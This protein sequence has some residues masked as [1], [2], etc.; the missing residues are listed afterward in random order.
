MASTNFGR[1]LKPTR[2]AY[3]YYYHYREPLRGFGSMS[4]SLDA[5]SVRDDRVRVVVLTLGDGDFSWSLDLARYLLRTAL[6]K[7]S[8]DEGPARTN[9]ARGPRRQ[10][11]LIATG[12]D[13][14]SE[15]QSKYKADCEFALRELKRIGKEDPQHLQVQV[16]HEVNAIVDSSTALSSKSDLLSATTKADVVIFNHPHLGTEDARL[17]AQFLCHLFHSVYNVWLKS[18]GGVFYLTLAHG[19]FERWKC[20]DAATRHEMELL[21][22]YCFVA[23]PMTVNE[24]Y[25]KHRRHQSGKSFAGRTSGSET[26]AFVRKRAREKQNGLMITSSLFPSLPWFVKKKSYGDNGSSGSERS[27]VSK[28]ESAKTT[29]SVRAFSCPQCE[30]S[31]REERSLKNHIKSKHSE[32][33]HKRKREDGLTC[34][35]C[36]DSTAIEKGEAEQRVFADSSALNAHIRAKHQ[37]IHRTILPEWAEAN[38]SSGDTT[39]TLDGNMKPMGACTI[40]GNE[41][42]S[43]QDEEEHRT[44]FVPSRHQPPTSTFA[45]QFCSKSFSQKRAQLQHENFC[46]SRPAKGSTEKAF[47]D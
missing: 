29:A 17:H 41:Y 8:D 47:L 4:G 38:K 20:M 11:Q 2:S 16:R 26:F 9:S 23:N 42:Y 30:K 14:V 32:G 40:C 13:S 31:F 10:V 21:D 25:Y 43:R 3:F 45:C 36:R 22:R 39:A 35:Y 24:P 7:N 44:V 18:A 19:Q 46:S 37:A 5:I 33:N 15:L 34:P 28:D 12:I 1:L 27:T 6:T